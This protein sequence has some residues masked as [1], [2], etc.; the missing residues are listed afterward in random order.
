MFHTI[1]LCFQGPSSTDISVFGLETFFSLL[2][3]HLHP[4]WSCFGPPVSLP[5][6]FLDLPKMREEATSLQSAC[7]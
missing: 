4:S 2:W 7:R 3:L 1:A 5:K 6:G